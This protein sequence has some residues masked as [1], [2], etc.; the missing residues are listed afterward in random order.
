MIDKPEFDEEIKK[1]E[2]P[3]EYFIDANE[4]FRD[5]KVDEA[6]IKIFS[7]K[8]KI[9][10]SEGCLPDPD[11]MKRFA[12]YASLSSYDMLYCDDDV[13][14]NGERT[15]PFI[16]PEYAPENIEAWGPFFGTM[17]V[18]TYID[19]DTDE[20]FRHFKPE[21]VKHIPEILCHYINER[22]ECTGLAESMIPD[23]FDIDATSLS[24]IILSKDH[25][26]LIEKCIRSLLNAY[27]P[28][29][30][31]VI[32]IDNGSTMANRA[33]YRKLAAEYS[34][35]YF[36]Q[37]SEFN[38]SALCNY[39]AGMASGEYLL[40]LNDDIVMPP[41]SSGFIRKLLYYA[42]RRHAGAVGMKLLYPEGVQ[43]QHCGITILKSGPSH[44]LCG[45]PDDQSFYHG[46]NKR[47]VNF[48]AVTG[49]CLC[50][51]KALFEKAGGFDEALPVS[52]NDVELCIRLY[53]MG[54]YNIC[55][56]DTFLIHH[57]S[58]TRRNDLTDVEAYVKM[59]EY[60]RYLYDKHAD[61]LNFGDPF[62]SENLT[63]TGLDYA[64][65]TPEYWEISGVKGDPM[66]YEFNEVSS[67][68]NLKYNIDNAGY[69]ISDAYLNED[70]FE[71]SGWVFLD[72]KDVRK[73]E[74]AILM[75]L[76]E[77]RVIYEAD[78]VYRRDLKSVFPRQ[79]NACMAGFYSRISRHGL[80]REGLTG[81]LHIEP[82]VI[83][84][85]GRV[86][87]GA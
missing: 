19:T 35:G 30:T 48:L 60:R 57:E 56:N 6:D 73:Y 72:K 76:G 50:I 86:Y 87:I 32:V 29:D 69:R 79:K 54:F 61:V 52:Y 39:G 84:K 26:E 28:N 63:Q 67:G 9:I 24:V 12:Y 47:N 44:K 38:Y 16:K 45:Y 53:R 18:R 58:A 64:L 82:V 42:E 80:E 71:I 81:S 4:K 43:I 33:V 17:A 2:N 78:R 62:Y 14:K 59:R 27:C 40:F 31:E 36:V 11:M 85:K 15:D 66:L 23:D 5:Q 3:Y 77:K 13:L 8:F 10:K 25:P 65:N 55:V 7:Q 41:E 46:I 70:F 83:D 75:T 74:P 22:P 68:G 34:F 21:R 49:A 37:T 51:R 20:W 1:A